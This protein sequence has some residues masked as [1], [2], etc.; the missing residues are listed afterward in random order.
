V[1]PRRRE[2]KAPREEG[3]SAGCSLE[4]YRSRSPGLAVPPCRRWQVGGR[5][6][7]PGP[8]A[9]LSIAMSENCHVMLW[10]V[11]KWHTRGTCVKSD[12]GASS[13]DDSGLPAGSAGRNAR[14]NT[15]RGRCFIVRLS[16]SGLS[17]RGGE[18]V[19][20]VARSTVTG[21]VRV[22]GT[23]RAW[24]DQSSWADRHQAP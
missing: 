12:F 11:Q 15:S 16:R 6:V 21:G 19:R 17:G 10:R 22:S 2:R 5:F 20:R 18:S 7:G 9:P 13:L 8:S 1:K 14:P 3:L 24:R 4:P 23:G